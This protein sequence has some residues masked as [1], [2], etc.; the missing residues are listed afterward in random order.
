[1]DVKL[2]VTET[3]QKNLYRIDNN[4]YKTIGALALSRI[5]GRMDSKGNWAANAP[6]T[7][8]VKRGDNPLKD[9]GALR[10]SMT[11]TT[12]P[13]AVLVGTNL[14]YARMV[15]DGGT[16][17][18]KKAKSL[19]IPAT[20]QTRTFMRRYGATPRACI[21]GM[22]A[23]GFSVWTSSNRGAVL[24]ASPAMRKNETF[25]LLFILRKK[26]TVPARPFLSLTDE[27]IADLQAEAI[28][29]IE[30]DL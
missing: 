16:I 9:S 26:V 4:F 8:N 10:N 12:E 3:G 1:M 5:T 18:P 13:D 29:Y 23:A 17:T 24:Y 22:K 15:H 28:S 6:L 20:A 19:A 11:F 27:D 2:D 21:D 30:G 14:G 7:R 25:D